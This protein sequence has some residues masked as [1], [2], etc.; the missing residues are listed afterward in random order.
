MHDLPSF[1]SRSWALLTSNIGSIVSR[2]AFC[3]RTEDLLLQMQTEMATEAM[4]QRVADTTEPAI[5][6]TC[7][8]CADAA[9]V[10]DSFD[11]VVAPR[12]GTYAFDDWTV[13]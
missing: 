5:A 11:C 13:I 2:N 8:V 10:A 9:D 7:E 12:V 4:I 3:R 1:M 6:A